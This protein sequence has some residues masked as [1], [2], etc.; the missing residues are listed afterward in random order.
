MYTAVIPLAVS[1]MP[2]AGAS[3][4]SAKLSAEYSLAFAPVAAVMSLALTAL[5]AVAASSVIEAVFG[6]I[7]VPASLPA[8]MV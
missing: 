3:A 1:V 4:F 6:S 8:V 5:A 7:A 2:F